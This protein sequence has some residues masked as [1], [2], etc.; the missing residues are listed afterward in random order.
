MTRDEKTVAEQRL[1]DLE[2][3]HQRQEEMLRQE[4]EQR[5]IVRL[6]FVIYYDIYQLL[7][8]ALALNESKL[9]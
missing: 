6:G 7:S 1:R 3:A 5:A 9:S 2:L 4:A 8:N